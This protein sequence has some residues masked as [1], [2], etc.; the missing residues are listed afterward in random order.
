[1]YFIDLHSKILN[2]NTMKKILVGTLIAASGFCSVYSQENEFDKKFRFGVRIAPQPTWI[3][4]KDKNTQGGGMNFGFGFGL[5]TEFKL[6]N[7]VHFSTGIGGDFENGTITYKNDPANGYVVG[8]Y[9]DNT[10]QEL[11][12]LS[13]GMDTA[14][15]F[16]RNNV[17]YSGIT[18]RK[19]KTTY[20]TIPLTLK[21]LTQEYS[22]F[23]YFA[24]FG[25][26]LGIRTKVLANDDYTLINKR[27]VTNSVNG[28]LTDLNIKK[29][30][31][32][33]PVRIGL[34]VGLGTEYRIAGTT[35]VLFSINYFSSF[36]NLMRNTSKYVVTNG[37]VD[38][39]GKMQFVFLKQNLIQ[40]AVRINVGILF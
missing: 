19:I 32:L 33:L 26:D 8:Y 27:G 40:N 5:I 24:Q 11:I 4:S 23:R 38:S 35:S 30:A 22:G 7:I 34:N 13:N 36:T 39:N 31:S 12:Q 17:G 20:V 37:Q 15:L 6:S 3:K 25:A 2:R 9:V 21:M 10:S 14:T 1:M 16:N 29:D 18:T 28:T